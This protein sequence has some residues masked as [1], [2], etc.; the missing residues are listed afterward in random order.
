MVQDLAFIYSGDTLRPAKVLNAPS[1]RFVSDPWNHSCKKSTPLAALTKAIFSMKEM[2]E[3]GVLVL[4]PLHQS[5]IKTN[6]ASDQNN[7]HSPLL[8]SC[9]SEKLRS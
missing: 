3:Q 9:F 8:L 4:K 2:Q 7:M 5:F 6:S 1:E